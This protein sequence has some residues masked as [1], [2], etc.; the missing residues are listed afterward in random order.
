MDTNSGLRYSMVLEER[1]HT[2]EKALGIKSPKPE[3]AK[4]ER[5]DPLDVAFDALRRICEG[6]SGYLQSEKVKAAELLIM[7]SHKWDK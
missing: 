3:E 7:Y 2:V 5:P 6:D 4:V 1:L